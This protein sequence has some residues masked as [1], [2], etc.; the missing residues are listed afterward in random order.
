M[1][2][3]PSRLKVPPRHVQRIYQVRIKASILLPFPLAPKK[4]TR[5][6][7]TK[8]N[9]Q[10]KKGTYSGGNRKLPPEMFVRKSSPSSPVKKQP[11]KQQT[12]DEG[13]QEFGLQLFYLLRLLWRTRSTLAASKHGGLVGWCWMRRIHWSIVAKAQP[14]LGSW[15][16][17]GV[18]GKANTGTVDGRKSPPKMSAKGISSISISAGLVSSIRSKKWKK[19][20]GRLVS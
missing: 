14:V 12:M 8:I 6:Q 2:A 5:K 11:S 15:F 13:L 16:R 7:H 17:N 9:P 1:S 18:L 19:K 3:K 20:L 4:H 10:K